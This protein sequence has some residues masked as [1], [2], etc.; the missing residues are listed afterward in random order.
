MNLLLPYS[1]EWPSLGTHAAAVV[2][3]CSGSRFHRGWP[4]R[5]TN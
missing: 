2:R 4:L 3:T 1:I 5:K